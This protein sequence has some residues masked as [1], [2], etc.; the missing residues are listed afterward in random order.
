ML[1]R[2]TVGAL[3]GGG[4]DRRWRGRGV[5]SKMSLFGLRDFLGLSTTRSDAKGHREK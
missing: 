4:H 5:E 3:R 1:D 2:L